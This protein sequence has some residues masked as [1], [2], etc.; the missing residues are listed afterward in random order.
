MIDDRTM[1]TAPVMTGSD[2]LLQIDLQKGDLHSTPI[3][4]LLQAV[5]DDRSTGLMK[6]G[7]EDQQKLIYFRDGKT[8]SAQST[9]PDEQLIELMYRGGVFEAHDMERIQA[10]VEESGWRSPQVEQIIDLPTQ[11]WWTRTLIREV[12]LSL[13]EWTEGEYAFEPRKSPPDSMVQVEMDTMKLLTSIL[14]RIQDIGVLVDILGGYDS[15]PTIN[16]SGFSGEAARTLTSE[17]GF[18][19]SRIDGTLNLQSILSMGGAQKLDMLRC[20]IRASMNGIIDIDVYQ[21]ADDT[22]EDAMSEDGRDTAPDDDAAAVDE[23]ADNDGA[24]A[25]DEPDRL[26]LDDSEDI[27]LTTD[28]LKN[29]RKLAGHL[30]ADFLDLSK[31]LDLDKKKESDTIDYGAK[32]T[33]LR[34]SEFVESEGAEGAYNIDELGRVTSHE[35]WAS[36]R[37]MDER[38]SLII[39]GKE[40]D[41]ESDLFGSDLSKE[42]FEAEDEEKQWNIWMISEEELNRD[43]A[44]DWT[45]TW[46]DWIENTQELRKLRDHTDELEAA[47]R[48]EKDEKRREAIL[49]ELKKHNADLQQVINRKKRQIFS[50]HRRMQLMNYY[51]LLRVERNATP[52]MI[53]AAF[54]E[55]E[56]EISPDD[57][58]IREFSSIAPQIRQIMDLLREAFET[59]NDPPTRE[60]YNR[61]LASQEKAAEEMKK[62]KAILAEDHLMSAR[63]ANR[64]GDKMLALR[65]LRGSISLDPTKPVY[66]REMARLLAENKNWRREALRFYHKAYHL[67][68]DDADVLFDVAELANSLNLAGFSKRVLRQVLAKKPS[69][70]KAKRLLQVLES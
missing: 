33:Y 52:E 3:P 56:T 67:N 58:L 39:G 70:K 16:T 69:H 11:K 8:I 54:E 53:R 48:A 42:I 62:K 1:V 35:D 43:Y 46:T 49:S 51:D 34:G 10:L 24:A 41:G 25:S 15:V 40:I 50:L 37:S 12:F 60:R 27:S 36:D 14:R 26:L 59:L 7:F 22:L 32:V 63:T 28:E 4:H 30:D 18:F 19:L 64:R 13:L 65:F 38:I 5:V 47:L 9:S 29:L 57:D 21:S 17:D 66:F 55:W 61:R 68:P 6:F 23:A 20:F 44:E 45:A 2:S 31:G